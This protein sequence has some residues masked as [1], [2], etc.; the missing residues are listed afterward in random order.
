MPVKGPNEELVYCPCDTSYVF[1]NDII[2]LE[3]ITVCKS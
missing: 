3:V 1:L 2:M